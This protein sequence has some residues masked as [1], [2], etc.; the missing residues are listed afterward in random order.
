[1]KKSKQTP[2]LSRR[3]SAL[4]WTAIA[5]GALLV[6]N[7]VFKTLLLFPSQAIRMQEHHLGIPGRPEVIARYRLP[8]V[9]FLHLLYLTGDE[10][11]TN[12]TGTYLTPLG[13]TAAFGVALDCTEPAPLYV[14]EWHMVRSEKDDKSIVW[15]GRIDDPLVSH[16]AIA[17][18]AWNEEKKQQESLPLVELTDESCYLEQNG[19]R[20]FYKMLPLSRN[21]LYHD[22]ALMAYDKEGQLLY[23][24]PIKSVTGSI[25]G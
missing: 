12:L 25:F 16:V 7:V 3:R 19:R 4:C 1:M 5:L 17:S 14:G 18:H 13:W 8:G 10:R 15:F 2:A 22:S 9:H 24:I 23:E 20:Y 11:S 6:L 21:Y